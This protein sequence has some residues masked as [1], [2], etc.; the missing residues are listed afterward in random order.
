MAHRTANGPASENRLTLKD[1]GIYESPS[2]EQADAT[3]TLAEVLSD[4]E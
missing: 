4:R 1:K 2:Q 3:R